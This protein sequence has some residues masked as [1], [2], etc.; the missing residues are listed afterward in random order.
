[1]AL[2]YNLAYQEIISVHPTRR[3]IFAGKTDST[4]WNIWQW[5]VYRPLYQYSSYNLCRSH[6]VI[7][8]KL[9]IAELEEVIDFTGCLKPCH[10]KKYS[11]LGDPSPS[12]FKSEHF[13][14]SL[15]AVSSKTNV[16]T[17]A[18]IYPMSTLVAEFGGTPGLFLGFSFVSFWD[19]CSAIRKIVTNLWWIA[20]QVFLDTAKWKTTLLRSFKHTFQNF[21]T[22]S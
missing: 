9:A 13:I 1:M 3:Q 5:V 6:G 12:N 10:Y 18:L 4:F 16:E 14:F 11:F 20:D 15:W 17:E 7:F 22:I 8:E 2:S 21:S 19:N